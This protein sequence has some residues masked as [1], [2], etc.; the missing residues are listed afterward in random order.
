[1]LALPAQDARFLGP[2]RLEAAQTF[3]SNV[4]TLF[5]TEHISEG[6][7]INDFVFVRRGTS[8]DAKDARGTPAWVVIV[9]AFDHKRRPFKVHNGR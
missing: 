5:R 1:M 6:W 4:I 9:R 3:I 7:Q 2:H 8:A